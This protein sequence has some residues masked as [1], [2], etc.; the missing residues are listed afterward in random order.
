MMGRLFIPWVF[1]TVLPTVLPTLVLSLV[2]L[3][4][5]TAT[6]DDLFSRLDRDGD[7]QLAS[8]EISDEH[9]TL[10]RRLLRT[11]DADGDGQLSAAEFAAGTTPDVPP[12]PLAKKPG[13]ELPG[14]ESLLLLL[15]WMDANA[16][17]TIQA[18]E[19][20]PD[21]K[22]VFGEMVEILKPK[23]P[24]QFR[25]QELQ[26]QA[27]RFVQLALRHTNQ[28][29]IDV[30]VELALLSE[31][32]YAL[33]ERIRDQG[34]ER[35]PAQP[36]EGFA[37]RENAQ[38]L[39]T[40][41]DRDGD[42]ELTT[43]E[44]PPGIAEQFANLFTQADR[45]GDQRVTEQEFLQL[46]ARLAR[47]ANAKPGVAGGQRITQLLQRADRNQDGQLSRREAPPFLATR[48]GQIDADGNGQLD[49]QE[50]TRAAVGK[51]EP[52]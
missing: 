21:L 6:A 13:V 5:R 31:E 32:H 12:K 42:G 9:A 4:A 25:I 35:K 33:V 14:A 18:R 20:P 46:Q 24:D 29:G 37:T 8:A 49:R 43:D 50:L 48:F 26:Q 2:C 22:P 38:A 16:D 40:R 45:D 41:L 34:K 3:L 51:F 52:K 7:G 27:P 30:E 36:G 1:P 17:Q 15:A 44:L 28:Q 39:F 47:R 23:T 11:A 19:V 10:F